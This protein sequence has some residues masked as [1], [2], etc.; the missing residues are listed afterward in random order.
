MNRRRLLQFLGLAPVAALTASEAKASVNT[1]AN[2]GLGVLDDWNERKLFSITA[3]MDE[4]MSWE[5]LFATTWQRG[6]TPVPEPLAKVIQ[7]IH[8]TTKTPDVMSKATVSVLGKDGSTWGEI[9]VEVHQLFTIGP[10]ILSQS[11]LCAGRDV[12]RTRESLFRVP[13]QWTLDTR[14]L[15]EQLKNLGSIQVRFFYYGPSPYQPVARGL[16]HKFNY[17]TGKFE[18]VRST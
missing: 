17:E 5:E 16:I 3:T 13:S 6:N 7:V 2:V 11:I 1:E 15:D 14:V 9:P 10:A 12:V 4:P 18:P 8:A